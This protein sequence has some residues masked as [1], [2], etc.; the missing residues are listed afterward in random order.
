MLFELLL[1]DI[2]SLKGYNIMNIYAT[3][4]KL[5]KDDFTD[6]RNVGSGYFKSTA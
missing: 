1:V 5:E 3:T 6:E 2:V 4:Q